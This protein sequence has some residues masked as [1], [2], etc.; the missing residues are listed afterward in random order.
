[1]GR[2]QDILKEAIKRDIANADLSL[3]GVMDFDG[4]GRTV[5]ALQ[6]A[7]S[8]NF[9]HT[10]AVKANALRS[11]LIK[12]ETSGIGAEVA[13]PGELELSLS[14]GFTPDRIIFDSPAKTVADLR[15]CMQ[16]G[17]S[18]N[19]DNEQELAR[20]DALRKEYPD[21]ASIIGFR[22]NPQIGS[23]EISSTSTATS[24]SKFGYPLAD[25]NNRER[26]LDIYAERPWLTS[27]HTHTGSQGCP[28]ELMATGI[29][30]ILEFAEE[31]NSARGSQQ[32]ERIDIGGGL[33]VNFKSEEMKPTFKDYADVL[34]AKVPVLFTDKYQVKTEFGR[35]IAA[36]NGFIITRVEYTKESGGRHIAITHA[37][38]QVT[39]RTAFLPQY[40]PI[41]VAGFSP[42]GEERS[43]N[44]VQTDVAG[45][46]CFAADLITKDT[47]LPKMEPNDYV[48]VFDTGAYY[49]SN[50]F[51]YN[52]L[53]RV[54]VYSAETTVSGL[55]LTLIRRAETLA[56]VV[57]NMS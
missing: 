15:G 27:I 26:L 33:P 13:S 49:F 38:A 57:R 19:L 56:D 42:D 24:T 43:D 28:L 18:F 52:S 32:I 20:V 30:V 29:A 45:P 44:P 10:F 11:V 55:E 34:R 21:T 8:P 4:L 46:C 50:H 5:Q 54:A 1:M 48:V 37:G 40:W 47:L 36:K 41:R 53:P 12:L 14:A 17:I 51:D 39:T 16:H 35:S 6:E 31:V 25:G 7:F 22:V 9:Y 3:V 2:Q 23:G